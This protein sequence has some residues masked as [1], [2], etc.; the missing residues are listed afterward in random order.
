MT[1]YG[2]IRERGASRT[3]SIPSKYDKFQVGDGVRMELSEDGRSFT[4]RLID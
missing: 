2:T 1:K 3:I 4:V